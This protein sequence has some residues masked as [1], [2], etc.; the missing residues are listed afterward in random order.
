MA[1]HHE[2]GTDRCT[3]CEPYSESERRFIRTAARSYN[4]R[5]AAE[6]LDLAHADY[7]TRAFIGKRVT[8][9]QETRDFNK[10]FERLMA[11]SWD[12]ETR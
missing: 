2:G 8:H 10:K 11:A 9:N 7:D 4:H 6:L 3:A 1:N 5:E 12:E